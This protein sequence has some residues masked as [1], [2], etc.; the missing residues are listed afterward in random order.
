M[1][2][3]KLI[4]GLLTPLI[5][6][7]SAWL[8]G[9]AAKYGLHLDASGVNALGVAGA[10]AGAAAL[11]KLIH[12][13]EAKPQVR[14]AVGDVVGFAAAEDPKAKETLEDVAAQI[15]AAAEARFQELAAKIP[16]PAPAPVAAV[17]DP[18]VA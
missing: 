2:P 14:S 7:G 10:T 17:P 8:A 9:A 1:N 15:Y 13:V 5:A 16:A 18:P 4:L 11:V 12:D 6:A 3:T